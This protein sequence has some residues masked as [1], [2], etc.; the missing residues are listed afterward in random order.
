MKSTRFCSGLENKIRESRN[1]EITE[2]DITRFICSLI[3]FICIYILCVFFIN[4]STI[5]WGNYQTFVYG[6]TYHNIPINKLNQRQASMCTLESQKW[7]PKECRVVYFNVKIK[8]IFKLQHFIRLLEVYSL[9]LHVFFL[10]YT[11]VAILMTVMIKYMGTHPIKR[12][13]HFQ[14]RL[15]F[16]LLKFCIYYIPCWTLSLGYSPWN[17]SFSMYI[18]RLLTLLS[19]YCIYYWYIPWFSYQS[20]VLSFVMIC[21]LNSTFSSIVSGHLTVFFVVVNIDSILL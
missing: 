19:K 1:F 13:F 5:Y 2:F 8:K 12:V 11:N 21:T 6:G 20:Q 18:C 9:D 14:Y 3:L 10:Q 16:L 15:Y 4:V 7:K 17:L